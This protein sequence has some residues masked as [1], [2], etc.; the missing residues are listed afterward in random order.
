LA[1]GFQEITEASLD[2]RMEALQAHS[3]R[4]YLRAMFAGDKQRY[5]TR[6]L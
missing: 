1:E 3:Y 2:S 6:F 4:E 5:I